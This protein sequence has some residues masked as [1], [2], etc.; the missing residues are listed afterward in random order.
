M[1]RTWSSVFL[2]PLLSARRWHCIPRD[3]QSCTTD[4]HRVM[5]RWTGLDLKV[6]ERKERHGHLIFLSAFRIPDLTLDTSSYIRP[7][8]SPFAAFA[9]ARRPWGVTGRSAEHASG[10][11]SSEPRGEAVLHL[12]LATRF[13]RVAWALR[14]G[15]Q[16]WPNSGPASMS[17]S[18]AVNKP[19]SPAGSC[20]ASRTAH[21][22]VRARTAS[23]T[24][25]EAPRR[26]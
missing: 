1:S 17:R 6:S 5:R 20:I 9:A 3:A 22:P 13:S 11:P 15:P 23:P 7:F 12:D 24:R 4:H 16:P 2:S 8:M 19:P 10:G 14:R 18:S 26:M 25:A 21:G